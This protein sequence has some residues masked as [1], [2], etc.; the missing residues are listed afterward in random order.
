M[1]ELPFVFVI[2]CTAIIFV[3]EGI[4]YIFSADALVLDLAEN[5]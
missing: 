1:L 5:N 2:S 3:S 4:A